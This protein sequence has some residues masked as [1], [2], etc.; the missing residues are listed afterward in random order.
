MWQRRYRQ[1]WTL[2]VTVLLSAAWAQEAPPEVLKGP[3]AGYMDHYDSNGDG[4]LDAEEQAAV[5][6]AQKAAFE[7]L[8][9]KHPSLIKA[10]DIDGD[11][12]LSLSEKEM[13]IRLASAPPPVL[14]IM[15]QRFDTN[16]DGQLSPEEQRAMEAELLQRQ[17]TGPPAPATT[18]QV[19]DLN[20]DGVISDAERAAARNALRGGDHAPPPPATI[21]P[22]APA[23]PTARQRE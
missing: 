11:G 3:L 13:A 12:Q 16:H 10:A 17:P 18:W 8:L 22:K 14:A 9:V 15:M 6:R 5:R 23:G 20:G 4:Q 19:R 2:G 7:D 1:W 21:A